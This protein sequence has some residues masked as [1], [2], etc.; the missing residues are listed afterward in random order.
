[1]AETVGEHE[2]GEDHRRDGLGR[3]MSWGRRMEVVVGHMSGRLEI[4][5]LG[6]ELGGLVLGHILGLVRRFGKSGILR[7]RRVFRS[8]G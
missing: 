3:F 1:M 7:A 4:L 6:L 5:G 8:L 2:T